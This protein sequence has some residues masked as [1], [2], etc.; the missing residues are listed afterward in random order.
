MD[1]KKVSAVFLF[2]FFM[3]YQGNV[4][5]ESLPELEPICVD[6]YSDRD[7]YDDVIYYCP[8][9]SLMTDEQLIDQIAIINQSLHYT[10][11]ASNIYFVNDKNIIDK[12]DLTSL[13]TLAHFNLFSFNITFNPFNEETATTKYLSE[14]HHDEDLDDGFDEGYGSKVDPDCFVQLQHVTGGGVFYYYCPSILEMSIQ[15]QFN[16]VN[17]LIVPA[18]NAVDGEIMLGFVYTKDFVYL[19]HEPLNN[20]IATY[21]THDQVLTI[22]PNDIEREQAFYLGEQPTNWPCDESKI[23]ILEGNIVQINCLAFEKLDKFEKKE[24]LERILNLPQF[25]FGQYTLQLVKGPQKQLIAKFFSEDSSLVMYPNDTLKMEVLRIGFM[26]NRPPL[27]IPIAIAKSLSTYSCSQVYDFY[28]TG[29]ELVNPPFIVQ[30]DTRFLSLTSEFDES[31][32]AWCRQ[33]SNEFLI[34]HT[35]NENSPFFVCP[36]KV[37]VTHSIG[38]LSIQTDNKKL[39]NIQWVESE[40]FETQS[41]ELTSISLFSFSTSSDRSTSEAESSISSLAEAPLFDKN[42]VE[43]N[44]FHPAI[45][46]YDAGVTIGFVCDQKNKQWKTFRSE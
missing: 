32:V 37:L 1:I 44:D 9:I 39:G 30:P 15:Q 33:G 11:D 22:F 12:A 8:N 38:G 29:I 6:N 17:N 42:N 5:A 13:N 45:L 3:F 34:V 4:S 27:I 19:E 41:N 16:L 18:S 2:V 10:I 21:Y 28:L 26:Q 7:E 20:L 46:S 23:S 35:E 24:E 14:T 36:R 25:E 40:V 43:I 31:F